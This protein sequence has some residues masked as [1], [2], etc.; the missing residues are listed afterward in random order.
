M[1]GTAVI[2]TALAAAVIG[3]VF[4]PLHFAGTTPPKVD[5]ENAAQSAATPEPAT[6]PIVPSP[7]IDLNPNFFLH[8]GDGQ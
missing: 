2:G 5:T 1:R 7:V 8:T 3:I 6:F 4:G